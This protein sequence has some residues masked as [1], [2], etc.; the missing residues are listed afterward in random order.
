MPT[1]FA[2]RKR[3]MDLLLVY[4]DRLYSMGLLD[5]MHI[6]DFSRDPKDKYEYDRG[7]SLVPSTKKCGN[8]RRRNTEPVLEVD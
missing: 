5:E 8:V 7:S 6:W 3:N 2:G 1:C 4:T